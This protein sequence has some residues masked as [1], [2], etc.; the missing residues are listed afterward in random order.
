MGGVGSFSRDNKTLYVSGLK[1]TAN[2][3]VNQI[4]IIINFIV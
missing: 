3:E 2:L 4:I 1:R